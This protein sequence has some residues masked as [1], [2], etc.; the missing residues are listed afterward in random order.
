[1]KKGAPTVPS[2]AQVTRQDII[3]CLKTAFGQIADELDVPVDKVRNIARQSMTKKERKRRDQAILQLRKKA[4][5]N[6]Q[7]ADELGLNVSTIS[8]VIGKFIRCGKVNP[9]PAGRPYLSNEEYARREEPIIKL[10]EKKYSNQKIAERLGI[11]YHKVTDRAHK[12]ISRG[13]VKKRDPG[14]KATWKT[15]RSS[16][17]RIIISMVKKRATLGEIAKKLGLTSRERA[18]QLI[19]KI[20]TKHGPD[21]FKSNR[22]LWTVTEAA[23]ELKTKRE[24]INKIC[25]AGEVSCRRRNAD[26]ASVWLIDNAGMKALK[27]HPLITKQE[28]C[29]VCGKSFKKGEGEGGLLICSEKCRKYLNAER[30]QKYS[31]QEPTTDSL[32]GWV[33]ELWQRLQFYVIP[34]DEEWLTLTEVE[35]RSQLSVMQI[36]WLRRRKIVTIRPHPTKM[37]RG[38]PVAT[39]S[40]SEMKIASEI[41]KAYTKPEN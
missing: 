34:D 18:R 23:E 40:A 6:E 38:Q 14:S 12:L 39:Y 1:M 10:R 7:I 4:Y 16:R 28:F 13:L 24:V 8:G 22:R 36:S 29:S 32:G 9:L 11:S 3:Q 31:T 35:Q 2:G 33:K 20:K 41:C 5:S 19:N 30:H 27:K 25:D 26:D 37:W 15:L 21:V 17:T